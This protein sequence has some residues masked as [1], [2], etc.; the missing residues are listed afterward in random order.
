MSTKLDTGNNLITLNELKSYL[1]DTKSTYHARYNNIINAV[2]HSFNRETN[3]KLKSR[4]LTEYYD[5][6]G[7]TVLYTEQYPIVSTSTTI[8]IRVDAERDYTTGDKIG[9]TKIMIDAEEGRIRLDDDSFDCGEHSVKIVY[10]AGYT[11]TTTS[12]ATG[13]IPYDLQYAALEYA[14]LL[15]NR[16]MRNRVGV[17]SEAGEGGSI[18]YEQDMPWGVKNTLER[19]KNVNV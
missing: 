13:T 15:F 1:G 16:E 5:G 11:I 10:T 14:R 7:G 6:D 19:Y 3:R 2:S 9:S 17:R 12:G 18:T 8:D 4:S